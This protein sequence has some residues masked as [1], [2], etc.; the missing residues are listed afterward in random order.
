[1]LHNNEQLI[2]YCLFIQHGLLQKP[3]LM[4]QKCDKPPLV[5]LKNNAWRP[6][7]YRSTN[8]LQHRGHA[9]YYWLSGIFNDGEN[10][11]IF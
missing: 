10:H 6:Y 9:G 8:L 4:L 1:M 3:G 5:R 2:T 11:A 7:L